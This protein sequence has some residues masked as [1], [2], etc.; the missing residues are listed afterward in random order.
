M[1]LIAKIS[2]FANRIKALDLDDK[3]YLIAC[4][5]LFV[6]VGLV[7]ASPASQGIPKTIMPLSYFGFAIG[8]VVWCWPF[9]VNAWAHPVG[10]V[11]IAILHLLVLLLSTAF[12]RFVVA[13]SLGLPPQDFDLT[14]SFVVIALYI[15]VWSIVASL[16]LGG[17]ALVFEIFGLMGMIAPQSFGSTVKFFAHMSGA[18]VLCFFFGRT[19]E[20]VVEHERYLYPLI[21]RVA[22]ISDFQPAAKY[23]GIG[24]N[25]RIRLHENG[26]ISFAQIQDGEVQIVVRT[27]DGVKFSIN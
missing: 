3:I 24:D 10:K 8:F 19:F 5:V 6:G 7:W 27:I 17:A 22:F 2:S 25:E 12:A 1:V 23:P 14:V 21:K 15:P 9:L 16:F 26:V 4:G 18:L 13:S 11:I 20:Y